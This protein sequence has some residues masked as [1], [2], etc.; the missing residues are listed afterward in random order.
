MIN[1]M[2]ENAVRLGGRKGKDDKG[3]RVENIKKASELAP[4]GYRGM[5]SVYLHVKINSGVPHTCE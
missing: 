3:G 4:I 2:G 5:K 1:D